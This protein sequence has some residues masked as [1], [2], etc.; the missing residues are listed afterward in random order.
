[1]DEEI[2]AALRVDPQMT[3][4]IDRHGPV[5]LEPAENE[6]R[7]LARSIINQQLST[8]SAT[9]VRERAFATLDEVSPEAV[10]DADHRTLREAGL[11]EAKVEYLRESAHAFLEQDLS[12][13]G[14]AH[15]G[16][17]AVVDRLTGIRGIGEWTAEM[18][19][20]FVLGREDVL[21]L[22]DLAVRRGIQQLYGDG[23]ELGRAEMREIAEDWRPYR[24]YGTR[25]VW[26]EYEDG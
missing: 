10:L 26:L 12:R 21:P 3:R 8:A 18:Y 17:E 23:A 24:S 14:L 2:R 15:L 16:D 11:S 9:A 13:D 22:G 6:F 19:L 20:M 7:R 4:L 1:M 25:Y 5:T